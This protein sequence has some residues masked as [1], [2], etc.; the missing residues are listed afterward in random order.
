MR[1]ASLTSPKILY[2]KILADEE[3]RIETDCACPDSL[4]R[5]DSTWHGN[6]APHTRLH[7]TPAARFVLDAD[8]SLLFPDTA[9]G[10]L[11]VVNRAAEDIWRGFFPPTSIESYAREHT[12]SLPS[13]TVL[14]AAQTLFQLG[15]LT[16][17]PAGRVQ[18]PRPATLTAW[19]HTTNACNLSCTY[20][21]LDKTRESMDEATGRASIEAVFRSAIK[22]GFN[23]IKFK[24]AGGEATLNFGLVRSLHD[25]ARTMAE[26]KGIR[27]R[28]VVLSN[29]VSLTN[30][31]I[32]FVRETGIRLMISLDG[33]EAGHDAQRIFAN[34][35]GS[36]RQTVNGIERALDRG[37]KPH[38]SITLTRHNAATVAEAVAYAIER[39]LLF[40]LNFYRDSAVTTG[41]EGLMAEDEE[42]I[43]GARTAFAVIEN[44]LPRHSL[45]D[46]LLDRSNFSGPHERSCGAGHSYLVIDQRGGV[47]RC[48]MEIER[49]VTNI[50][51][52]DP[53]ALVQISSSGFNNNS[54]EEKEGCRDCQ[55][56]YWCAGGCP[57]LTYRVT[58][59]NDVKSPYCN[60][61]K[62]LFPE[63][64]RLEGL[65]LLKWEQSPS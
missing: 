48:Q 5:F 20:C 45:I 17:R 63:I 53:L 43:A 61:Y 59:R 32:D 37:I 25:Y 58:G 2:R 51:A 55:W 28:E 1:Q 31:M 41:R 39:D 6:L 46:G 50:M 26:Q 42:L 56:R 13:E 49:T 62:T 14:A 7:S 54:V 19:I 57:M 64:L 11:V 10:H 34:G 22:H 52:E 4:S 30:S 65:R 60:V 24:Y 8:H 29:G 21:Y 15:F 3:T 35:R 40:N 16:D 47:A 33:F 9:T 23:E 12:T 18:F 36:S 38:L 44:R 27:L